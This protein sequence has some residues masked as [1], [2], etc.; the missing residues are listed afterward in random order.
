MCSLVFF[1]SSEISAAPACKDVAR[2]YLFGIG[3]GSDE[4]SEFGRIRAAGAT[5]TGIG[6]NW[7]LSEPSKGVYDFS[8]FDKAYQ[9]AKKHNLFVFE[10]LIVTTPD[11]AN[12]TSMP[13]HKALPRKEYT[14]EYKNFVQTFARRYPDLKKYSFWNEPNGCGSSAPDRCGWT[15]DSVREY[16]YWL[17]V[18][19]KAL[20]EVD[21]NLRLAV[22]GLDGNDLSFIDR[23]HESPGGRSYDAFSLHPYN[24][25][26]PADLHGVK[27][28]YEKVQKPIV[29]T[30]FGW[31]VTPG[32]D[33][34]SSPEQVAE[35][36]RQTFDTLL[37]D[38]FSFIEAVSLHTI[39][40]FSD[41]PRMGLIGSDGNPRP[42]HAVYKQYATS[43]CEL[44]APPT[45]TPIPPKLLGDLNADRVVDI[46]DY[47]LV[48]Q[49]FDLVNCNYNQLGSC[50]IDIFDFNMVVANFGK[51]I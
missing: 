19:Y 47:Q 26:G 34:S 39:T 11:W 20:K 37:T 41:N 25:H 33:R 44:T 2:P 16:A 8:V 51:R 22:G 14:Q 36:L 42:A 15:D 28:V 12:G 13:A 32:N 10:V 43:Y 48:T 45:P 31:S 24:W 5:S 9:G 1:A 30:E 3:R 40:D 23:L 50:W 4:D 27:Q 7:Y 38:Q 18:T 17:D 6:L 21:P 46:A 49:Y 29:I 35:Y